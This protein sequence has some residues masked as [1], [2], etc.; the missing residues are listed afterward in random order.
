MKFYGFVCGFCTMVAIPM[1]YSCAN[2]QR[3]E[4]V[5]KASIYQAELLSCVNKS[6]TLEESRACRINVMKKYGRSE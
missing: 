3:A 6:A 2:P 5:E 4:N 1:G